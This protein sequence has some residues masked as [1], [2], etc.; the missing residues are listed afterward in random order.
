VSRFD[1]TFERTSEQ[2]AEAGESNRR[3]FIVEDCRL[4][5][6][7]D[8]LRAERS[9]MRDDKYN[10]A[11]AF[12]VETGSYEFETGDTL[13]M[14]IRWPYTVTRASSARLGRLLCAIL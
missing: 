2:E 13:T 12:S 3:G 1:V 8:A 4:R 11:H 10:R 14:G 9:S 5:D 7:V 6:A